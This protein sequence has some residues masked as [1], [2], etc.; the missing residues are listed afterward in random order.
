[1]YNGKGTGRNRLRAQ[2]FYI[3]K[4]L[5]TEFQGNDG[6]KIVFD[7]KFVDYDGRAERIHKGFNVAAI[8]FPV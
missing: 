5:R 1:M 8:C 7:R 2:S 3:G 6:S 4:Q